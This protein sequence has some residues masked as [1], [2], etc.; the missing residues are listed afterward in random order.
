MFTKQKAMQVATNNV[1]KGFRYAT[2]KTEAENGI[3]V[4][5]KAITIHNCQESG[6]LKQSDVNVFR[7]SLNESWR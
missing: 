1:S 5:Y 3:I 7:K 2:N 6:N 4:L